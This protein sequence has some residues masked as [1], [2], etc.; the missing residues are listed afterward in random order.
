MSESHEAPTRP[1][2]TTIQKDQL[3]EGFLSTA[4]VASSPTPEAEAK[5]RQP[6]RHGPPG[7]AQQAFRNKRLNCVGVDPLA[8]KLLEDV[9]AVP[10]LSDVIEHESGDHEECPQRADCGKTH[11]PPE[12]DQ[13]KE[14]W[15]CGDERGLFG[16]EGEEKEEADRSAT[17]ARLSRA[18]RGRSQQAATPGRVSPPAPGRS[19]RRSPERWRQTTL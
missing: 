19:R 1:T 12:E 14:Q 6:D 5:T 18:E 9:V 4:G 11:P 15:H 3:G 17:L 7:G 13:V 10:A 2:P 8:R 16:E